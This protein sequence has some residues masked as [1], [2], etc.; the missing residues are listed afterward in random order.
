MTLFS[1]AF[2]ADGTERA[3]KTAAQFALVAFGQD[4]TG[5]DIFHAD[6]QRVL[7]LAGAGAVTSILTSIVSAPV[8]GMS[9]ASVAPGPPEPKE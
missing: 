6:W 5:I 8:R 1:Q 2:W 4:L 7:G 3:I 9:P